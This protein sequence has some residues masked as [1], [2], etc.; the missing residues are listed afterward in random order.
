MLTGV[1][2]F[3]EMLTIAD[4]GGGEVGDMLTMADEG[5]RGGGVDSPLF[6]LT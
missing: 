4:K 2:G 6:W 5:E 1:R 3:G